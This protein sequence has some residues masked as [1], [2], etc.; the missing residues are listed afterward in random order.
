MAPESGRH[1]QRNPWLYAVIVWVGVIFFSST[2]SALAWCEAAFSFLSTFLFGPK[3]RE[4]P[5]FPIFHL[6]ADKGLHVTLFLVLAVLLWKALPPGRSKSI[7]ILVLGF[8]VGCCSEFLQ[9]FFPDRDPA[10]RDVL[11]NFFGTSLGLAC[12]LF[13]ASRYRSGALNS[14]R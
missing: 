6:L 5:S 9:R 1:R 4:H 11:I 14:P 7:Q 3:V 10:I 2:S 8:L 12:A 13:V